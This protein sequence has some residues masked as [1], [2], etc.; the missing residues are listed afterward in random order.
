MRWIEI[1][2]PHGVGKTTLLRGYRKF[3]KQG[4]HPIRGTEFRTP[5][6]ALDHNYPA[7]WNLPDHWRE[8]ARTVEGLYRSSF[9]DTRPDRKRRRNFCRAVLRM[10]AIEAANH[11]LLSCMD[12]LGSEGMR[13]SFALPDINY[14]YSY[15][16][17]MPVSFGVVML[18]ADP[19]VII[20][21][22]RSRGFSDFGS[23]TVDGARVCK[24][25]HEVLETRTQV[26]ALDTQTPVEDNVRAIARFAGLPQ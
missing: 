7:S 9:N 16:M 5:A 19:R 12:L 21:R 11:D 4:K 1:M 8:F 20:A 18:T 2:G 14:M 24:I 13:M 6:E 25:A 23:S 10:V 15:Y 17:T 26:L 3:A 22:N